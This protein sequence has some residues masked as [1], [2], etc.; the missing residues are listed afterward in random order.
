[1]NGEIRY[2][3]YQKILS[4]L[5]Q[6]NSQLLEQEGILFAGGAR[7]PLEISEF[8]LSNT[9]VFWC[10]NRNA[11]S[12]IRDEVDHDG[13]LGRLGSFSKPLLRNPRFT[14]NSIQM[15]LKAVDTPIKLEFI[16]MD[17]ESAAINASLP[18]PV[19]HTDRNA[20]YTNTLMNLSYYFADV[21]YE[22]FFDLLAMKEAWGNI[23]YSSLKEVDHQLCGIQPVIRGFDSFFEKLKHHPDV[24]LR[25]A[26][27]LKIDD[28]YASHLLFNVSVQLHLECMAIALA[29]K[30]GKLTEKGIADAVVWVESN[31]RKALD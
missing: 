9:L 31:K 26:D 25:A 24:Y 2:A 19:P 17:V 3:H 8:R 29:S 12:A 10:K 16:L 28:Q 7:V 14:L 30:E 18:I 20:C 5:L 11:L 23:P 6:L 1:M 22:D 27:A 21:P 4:I 13:N 15:Y